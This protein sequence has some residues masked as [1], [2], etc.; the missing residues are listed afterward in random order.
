MHYGQIRRETGL[1]R[2]FIGTL[3]IAVVGSVLI[4]MVTPLIRRALVLVQI[5]EAT[6]EIENGKFSA[7]EAR[8]HR[9]REWAKYYPVLNQQLLCGLIRTKVRQGKTESGMQDAQFIRRCFPPSFQDTLESVR[10]FLQNGPDWVV[11]EAYS[12][13]SGD[14]RTWDPEIGRQVLLD[15]L[16]KQQKYDEVVET[17]RKILEQDPA[18]PAAK[19]ELALVENR[20]RAPTIIERPSVPR[21]RPAREPVSRPAAAV[22]MPVAVQGPAGTFEEVATEDPR[23]Q[24]ERELRKREA[25][26]TARLQACRKTLTDS[27]PPAEAEKARDAAQRRYYSLRDKAMKLEEEANRSTGQKRISALEELR[28]MKGQ[29]MSCQRAFENAGE[30]AKKADEKRRTM[31]E[32]DPDVKSIEKSLAEVRNE[33]TNL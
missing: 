5:E 20:E 3:V 6:R 12:A 11:N 17:A 28:R 23:E 32:D 26:L 27:R 30:A 15:E 29:M 7:A 2:S 13:I 25:E 21:L 10:T 31:I 24:K 33:L 19:V 1:M 22:V 4:V 16:W 8:L 18:D 9:Y 14:Q